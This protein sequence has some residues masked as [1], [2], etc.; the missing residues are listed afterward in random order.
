MALITEDR[1]W[2]AEASG[3]DL[4]DT[5]AKSGLQEARQMLDA[6]PVAI[7]RTD[8][9]GR[10][11]YFN[12]AAADLWG[13][14]PEL[15][16]SEFCGSWKLYTTDGQPMRHDECPMAVAL[17]ERRPVRNTEAVAERPDG[18]RVTFMPLPTPLYDT[19]GTFIGAMNVLVDI[20]ERK[21]VEEKLARTAREQAALYQFADR[22]NRSVSVAE[23]CDAAVDA[24]TSALACSRASVLLFDDAGVMQFAAWR[25][26]SESYRRAVAGH[27]PW[28][29]GETGARP[30]CIENVE[31]ADLGPLKSVILQEG[32]QALAFVPITVDGGVVGKF[33]AY[34]DAPHHI[35]EDELNLANTIAFQ[36]GINVAR[37]RADDVRGQSLMASRLHAAVVDSSDDGIMTKDLQGIITSWNGGAE[38]LYGYTA[39][40]VIGKPVSILMP[41]DRRVEATTI[42]ERIR[43][44]ER[45]EHYETVR[46]R[47]DGSLVDISLTV[48]P[49]KDGAGTIVGASKIARDITERR[50]AQD[51]QQ[52]L[53]REMEHR[54]KNLFNVA[55]SVVELSVRGADTPKALAAAVRDRLSALS[56]AHALTLAKPSTIAPGSAGPTM[57][58]DLIETI[59]APYQG[60]QPRIFITG[61][62]WSLGR[63]ATTSLALLFN[64]LAT[65]AAKYGSLSTPDG[66]V[67][68][69][70]SRH[71]DRIH[72]VWAERGGP[73]VSSS[74]GKEGFGSALARGV[75]Q[76]LDGDLMRDWRPDGL[77]V[78][79]TMRADRLKD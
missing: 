72:V 9:F 40:E 34:F 35:S 20:S 4:I 46:Q 63:T 70:S 78:R 24:I 18:S 50:R 30:I 14:R 28:R 2:N 42:L 44:G 69:T 33:M 58:L 67:A 54:I 16:K 49:I 38:R 64:E 41:P 3:S 11:T 37:M 62:D 75:A 43:N 8:E 71:G 57:M 79:V 74:D 52:M 32:I 6:V 55:A 19:T 17:R 10:I 59:V 12:E 60:Q 29:P 15:G 45:L 31:T 7:Y 66:F 68:V 76:Q 23:T 61:V 39:E 27:T 1:G 53:L 36:L 48:S 73:L 22:L 21:R 5:F 77:V 26:L 56:R 25:N 47:K 13:C 51:H 65:N